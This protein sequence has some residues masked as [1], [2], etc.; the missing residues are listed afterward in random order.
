MPTPEETPLPPPTFSSADI[1]VEG[2]RAEPPTP[3]PPEPPVPPAPEPTP[4]PEK[5]KRVKAKKTPVPT[6]T[7]TPAPAPAPAAPPPASP[8]TP[9]IPTTLGEAGM[10]GTGWKEE[11]SGREAETLPVPTGA[12]ERVP[13]APAGAVLRREAPLHERG[14]EGEASPDNPE[15]LRYLIAVEDAT[16]KKVN[17][18]SETALAP[19]RE[20]FAKRAE[21]AALLSG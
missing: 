21:T 3:E 14:A 11:A 10:T 6:P 19:L 5:K 7:P 16:G 12:V 18:R 17:R 15:F 4:T 1:S 20:A 13:A 9:P 8:A 2:A